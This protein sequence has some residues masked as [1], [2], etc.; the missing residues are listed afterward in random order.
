MNTTDTGFHDDQII[1]EVERRRSIQI[2][3][4]VIVVVA[5]VLAL[6]CRLVG[7]TLLGLPFAFWGPLAAI[8][9][10][11]K[12]FALF[13]GWRCPQCDGML[14]PSYS[15]RFCPNCGIRIRK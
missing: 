2:A 8:L 12:L 3:G 13:L 11:L 9:L 4:L 15:T 14:G 5:T 10:I 6:L 1:Q 7:G